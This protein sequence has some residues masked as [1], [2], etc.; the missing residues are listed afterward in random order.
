MAAEESIAQAIGREISPHRRLVRSWGMYAIVL[1]TILAIAFS[2][3][4]PAMIALICL[5]GFNLIAI[6]NYAEEATNKW[7]ISET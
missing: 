1:I 2:P 7:K 3:K 4:D 5:A 6:V